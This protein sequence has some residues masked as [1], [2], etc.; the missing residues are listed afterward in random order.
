MQ[1]FSFFSF[2][3]P[4]R[5]LLLKDFSNI[6]IFTYF[7]NINEGRSCALNIYCG[8]PYDEKLFVLNENKYLPLFMSMYSPS[9]NYYHITGAI[10]SCIDTLKY[11]VDKYTFT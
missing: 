9:V 5:T 6:Y 3:F 4:F 8:K 10:C 2:S 1:D 11:F 7:K